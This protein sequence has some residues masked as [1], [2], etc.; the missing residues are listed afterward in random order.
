M[1][2]VI[3]N[4]DY[5]YHFEII[6]SIIQKYD[7]IIKIKK[8][9]K[10][11]IYLENIDSIQYITYIN[12]IYPSI[13]I[14]QKID[15]Y[16][17]KIFTTFYFKELDNHIDQIN[18]PS[19]YFFICHEVDDN[20]KIYNNVFYLTP[21]CN[22]NNFIYADVLP[23]IK[24]NQ[25]QNNIPI[26]IIQGRIGT[27]RRNPKL[28]VRILS[29]NFIYNYKIKIIGKGELPKILEPFKDKIILKK[30][31]EFEDF[32]NEFSDIYCMLPL[33]TKKSH[34][35]YYTNKLTSTINYAKAYNLKCLIDKDLQDIYHLNNVEIFNDENDIANSFMKTLNDFYNNKNK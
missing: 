15:N 3:D 4:L 5:D 10:H 22:S 35:Q 24:Q 7:D 9:K 2:I 18:N 28:L 21:L 13:K 14:N 30:D 27:L 34:P 1:I 19:K 25:N 17:Y 26:Y 12:K 31:L 23:K 8:S 32:H 20:L 16:D 6:E 33:I 29:T 11:E